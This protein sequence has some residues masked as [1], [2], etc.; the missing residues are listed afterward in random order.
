MHRGR[1]RR[2][3]RARH[4]GCGS[5]A[6]DC[7]QRC[8]HLAQAAKAA[9][10]AAV[11]T[12][13]RYPGQG[14][15]PFLKY[16]IPWLIAL[17][18]VMACH[19]LLVRTLQND[20]FVDEATYVIIGDM[21]R[22][23]HRGEGIAPA[24]TY[25]SGAPQLYPALSSW[26]FA[27]GGL[28]IVRE[29]STA[30]MLV[31]IIAV[32]WGALGLFG[33]AWAGL[34][35][36]V[37]F[38][39][40]APVLFLSRFATYDAPALA[41]VAIAL[42]LAIA[43]NR[44]GVWRALSAGAL[45]GA[46]ALV[47]YAAL[48]YLPM[49]LVTVTWCAPRERRV[50]VGR[51]A[52]VGTTIAI[53]A[54]AMLGSPA[55]LLEG[56]ITT[57]LRRTTVSG[58]RPIDLILFAA[59]LGGVA[60]LV[61]AGGAVLVRKEMRGV[62]VVLLGSALLAP[63]NHVRIAEFVSLHKHMAFALVPTC[64]LAG[65]AL[66]AVY[67]WSATAWRRKQP[68]IAIAVVGALVAIGARAVA[69]PGHD[70]AVRLFTYWPSNTAQAFRS[71]APV[72][73]RDVAF[74]AEEPDLGPLYLRDKTVPT[75]WVHPY[76]FDFE[77]RAS[78]TPSDAEPYLRAIRA[79][80]FAGVV[81]RFGPQRQWAR[82]IEAELLRQQPAYRLAAELPFALADGEGTWQIWVRADA[83]GADAVHQP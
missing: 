21:V 17:G 38:A 60:F 43:P 15:L 52:M 4:D 49:V 9:H 11:Y 75:Q 33:T 41:L 46:A 39:T 8:G 14:L 6:N 37:L 66:A 55:A 69:W 45:V 40:Q 36:A 67:D 59:S 77:G 44:V 57:T 58:G 54:L 27:H 23:W 5:R 73:Q 79:R 71:L 81:L 83:V 10:L 34:G 13:P 20:A 78:R 35:A 61:A 7:R 68:V 2:C 31:A 3:N 62:A 18:A 32:A 74:L 42:A 16:W 48:L 65:G 25:L 63:L 47:K 28:E 64:V 72:A 12:T 1:R 29:L 53:A 26:L 19:V 82:A 30:C 80:H 51:T 70:E 56:F 50:L 76:Y 24:S 22:A